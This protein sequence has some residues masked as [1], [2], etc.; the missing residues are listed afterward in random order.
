MSEAFFQYDKFSSYSVSEPIK[1]KRRVT[2]IKPIARGFGWGSLTQ[3]LHVPPG[4][5]RLAIGNQPLAILTNVVVFVVNPHFGFHLF[6]VLV[7]H[8]RYLTVRN[9]GGLV[10]R[11][12]DG[13]LPVD[14]IDYLKQGKETGERIADLFMAYQSGYGL[15]VVH[16]FHFGIFGEEQHLSGDVFPIRQN[17]KFIDQGFQGDSVFDLPEPLLD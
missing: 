2:K 4:K 5:G 12:R 16:R 11:N 14:V 3:R 13:L 15:P 17:R 8:Q 10:A 1:I 9:A 6:A 7:A